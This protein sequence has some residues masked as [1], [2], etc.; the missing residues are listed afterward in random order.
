MVRLFVFRN[1]IEWYG[2]LLSSTQ[3][4]ELLEA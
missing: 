4:H 3:T 2:E 1:G